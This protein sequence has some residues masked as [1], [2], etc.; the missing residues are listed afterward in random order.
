M[1][2]IETE[3]DGVYIIEPKV[4]N[5]ARGY[6][7]EAWK[8]DEF[9]A[10]VGK[11]D[12]MQDNESK[13]SY[14]VLRGLHYQKG[15]YSQA[16]LVRV[17]KGRVLDVA[18]DIRKSSPTFG[19]HVMVELSDENKRQLFIPRGFAH[20]FLVLSEEAVFTYKVDNIY[21]PQYEAGIRWNDESLALKWP[22]APEDVLTSE[23]D[24][25]A[26]TLAEADLF[27]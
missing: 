23:K 2:Y 13:S 1:K 16:K 12:F 7:L 8:K 24:L 15:K 19:R 3:I 27:E 22:I 9:E 11:V 17:I 26:K 4:F 20:G 6:F 10:H 18:V 5:D 14:G 21:A 25:Q